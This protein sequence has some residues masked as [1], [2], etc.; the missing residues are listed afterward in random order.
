MEGWLE[1]E[2]HLFKNWQR[3]WFVVEKHR[4]AY[5]GSEQKQNLKGTYVLDKGSRVVRSPAKGNKKFI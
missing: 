1:K 5:Y 3:R 4:V 2:G